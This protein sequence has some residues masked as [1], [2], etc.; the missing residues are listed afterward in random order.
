MTDNRTLKGSD[1]NIQKAML[2]I[3]CESLQLV[4]GRIAQ[5]SRSLRLWQKYSENWLEQGRVEAERDVNQRICAILEIKCQDRSN[6]LKS[7][8]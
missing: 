1:A 8:F 5:A 2:A 6:S 7:Y 4:L 3:R